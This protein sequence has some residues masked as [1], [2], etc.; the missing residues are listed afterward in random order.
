M[1]KTL[2]AESFEAPGNLTGWTLTDN[3]GDFE[4]WEIHTATAAYHGSQSMA[5]YSWFDGSV[6]TP[7]NWAISARQPLK[8]IS[9]SLSWLVSAVTSSHTAE[10]YQVSISN[11]P[12]VETTDFSVLFEE[13]LTPSDIT[14]KHR[15]VALTDFISDTVF[16]AFVHNQST[17]QFALKIDSVSLR[18]Y[19]SL[20]AYR[21]MTSNE[22]NGTFSQLAEVDA[23][24]FTGT[25]TFSESFTE[26]GPVWVKIVAVFAD[27]GTSVLNS[28]YM[29][30]PTSGIPGMPRPYKI[31][32]NPADDR[33]V[34]IPFVGMTGRKGIISVVNMAGSEVLR[35]TFTGQTIELGV[36]G[37]PAGVYTLLLK[38]N[39]ELFFDKIIIGR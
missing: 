21:I 5:S 4:Q 13:T 6:L 32:P 15:S 19:N 14:W 35:E 29:I 28:A 22:E 2:I 26:P 23:T 20:T 7:D 3:D 24:G 27:G 36:A 8:G 10:H 16:V 9:A 30:E 25:G 33:L 1:V 31:Y 18:A 37:L 11:Q 38:T 12:E 17:D 34:F 39:E